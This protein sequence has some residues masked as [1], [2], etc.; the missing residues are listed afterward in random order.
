M[1]NTL[2]ILL[3][4]EDHNDPALIS[5]ELKRLFPKT[6]V[7]QITDAQGFH[8]ALE[9]GSFDIAI[10]GHQL[11]WSDGL[12]ILRAIKAHSPECPVIML[13]NPDDEEIAVEAMKAGLDD[14]VLKIRPAFRPFTGRRAPVHGT[15]A[16]ASGFTGRRGALPEAGR[17]GAPGPLP[18]HAR[19]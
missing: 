7:T 13:T 19:R 18:H 2:R 6:L 15:D 5:R 10:T 1:D 3:I 11:A 17:R 16:P 4:D 9:T 8:E 12:S 14:Y